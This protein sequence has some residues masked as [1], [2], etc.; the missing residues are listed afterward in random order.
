[1][2]RALLDDA[3]EQPRAEGLVRGVSHR[4]S[5]QNVLLELSHAHERVDGQLER[6]RHSRV[7][8][9]AAAASG[10]WE[11]VEADLQWL[12]EGLE[13][14]RAV[15]ARRVHVH[16][17]CLGGGE[18]VVQQ[19]EQPLERLAARLAN[20]RA[21]GTLKVRPALAQLGRPSVR[22]LVEQPR[23]GATLLQLVGR[24]GVLGEEERSELRRGF[25]KR[26]TPLGRELAQRK[27]HRRLGSTHRHRAQQRRGARRERHNI[28][29][30]QGDGLGA[31]RVHRR[32]RSRRLVSASVVVI[33]AAFCAP[34]AVAACSLAN[35]LLQD[36]INAVAACVRAEELGGGLEP[37]DEHAQRDELVECRGSGKERAQRREQ[38]AE[39]LWREPAELLWGRA[40]DHVAEDHEDALVQLGRLGARER[41]E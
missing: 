37:S 21:E 40:L 16:G 26:G 5:A 20:T 13:R 34:A 7:A 32:S 30:L 15:A 10:R 11:R 24:G 27:H 12:G 17:E 3:P 41:A 14:M 18:R 33:A 31:R 22:E 35:D 4:R 36:E 8:A 1:M 29:R 9:A 2:Q 38:L 23:H 39:L 28:L 6:R 25:A 19:R